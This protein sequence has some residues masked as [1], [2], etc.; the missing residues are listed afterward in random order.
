MNQFLSFLINGVSLGAIY[1]LVAI[2]IVL[3]YKAS[4]VVTF[5]HGALV[6]LGAFVTARVSQ[7]TSFGLAVVAA[8]TVTALVAL[9]A[10]RL[11]IR[12]MRGSPVINLSIATI[13]IDLLLVTYLTGSIGSTVLNIKHPWGAS[14][15]SLWGVGVGWNRVLALVVALALIGALL[16]LF[17]FS[18]W[19]VAMRAAAQD[20][21][22]ASLMGIGLS[23]VSALTW[24]V[25]GALAC[26]AGIFL[27][28]APTPGVTVSLAAIA[29]RAFPAAILGGL[30]SVGGALVGGLVI[31]I[32]EALVA[33]YQDQLAF[34]GHGA[35]QVVP[36]V[37]MLA[38][39]LIRPS[40]LFGSKELTRV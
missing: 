5:S 1:G 7:E 38:V 14:N 18:T 33:G 32:L 19:G 10:E 24:M 9:L 15:L 4:H 36:Y 8:I 29:F 27:A 25:A 13:G 11:V 22:I 12:G 28:G 2:G 6:L 16:A 17:K 37:V 35:S 3:I 23:K 31:G 34:L 40:G 20:G 26:V 39:L 30:D 21:E